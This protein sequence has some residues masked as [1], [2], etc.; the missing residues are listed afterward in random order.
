MIIIF[1][2]GDYNNPGPKT[3]K[4]PFELIIPRERMLRRFWNEEVRT[5]SLGGFSKDCS[6]G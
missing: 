4:S 3:F 1:F 6:S 2:L 5:L